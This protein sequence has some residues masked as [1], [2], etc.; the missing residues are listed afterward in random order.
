M[1]YVLDAATTKPHV[2]PKLALPVIRTIEVQASSLDKP[3]DFEMYACVDKIIEVTVGMFQ[4]KGVRV[5]QVFGNQELK[6][7]GKIQQAWD[8]AFT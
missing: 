2:T 8:L 4:R 1:K 3:F 6:L 5:C 7:Y